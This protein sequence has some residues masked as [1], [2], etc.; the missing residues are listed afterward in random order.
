[1]QIHLRFLDGIVT[2]EQP[3]F[4]ATDIFRAV[5]AHTSDPEKGYLGVPSDQVVI[6]CDC[7]NECEAHNIQDGDLFN[8]A[9]KPIFGIPYVNGYDVSQ[10]YAKNGDAISNHLNEVIWVNISGGAYEVSKW[11]KSSKYAHVHLV[12]HVTHYSIHGDK[13]DCLQRLQELHD[14]DNISPIAK[15]RIAYLIQH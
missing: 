12:E 4:S 8:I 14:S 6:S 9:I 7:K 2:V 3:N 10:F 15:E 11:E 13:E 1:M 5:K